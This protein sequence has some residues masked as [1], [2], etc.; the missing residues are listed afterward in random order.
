MPAEGSILVTGA[1]GFLG[2]AVCAEL[3]R[4]GLPFAAF[5]RARARARWHEDRGVPLRLGDLSD[6][7]ACREAVAGQHTVLHLAAAADVSAHEI[8]RRVNIDGLVQMLDASRAEGI[9][10][11]V[12]VSSNCA[13][14]E[15]RDAYGETKLEGEA[16][17]R[18]SGLEHTILRPTMIYGRGSKEFDTFAGIIRWSPVVPLIGSGLNLIQPVYLGDAVNV[19]LSALHEPICAGKTY[20][21][22][23]QTPISFDDMVHRVA[24]ALGRRRRLLLHIPAPPLL[25]AARL[26][27][28]LVTHVPLTVDQVM[29]F[30]QNTSVD[31]EPLR[32]D[33]GFVPRPLDAGLRAVFGDGEET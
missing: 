27:G 21:L 28:Q 2:R 33:L 30:L 20:D 17:V 5:A 16:L 6:G 15:H 12:F 29:A 31:L 7:K 4:R 19:L 14:R 13:G 8:N 11:F 18:N 22:A 25:W 3:H 9:A 24:S 23:G 26:L 32:R 10:R 1:T